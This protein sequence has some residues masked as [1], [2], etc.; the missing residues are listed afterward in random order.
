[1]LQHKFRCTG[2]RSA[3]YAL[4][5]AHTPGH[6]LSAGGDGWV[7]EWN[8]ADPETG[9]VVVNVETQ[10]FSLAVSPPEWPEKCILAGTMAGGL[11][12]VDQNQP[13]LGRNILHHQKGLFDILW[14][15][16]EV[17]TAGGDGAVSRWDATERKVT[18]SFQIS[19]RSVRSLAYSQQHDILAAGASDGNIYWM[20]RSDFT[21]LRTTEAHDIAVFTTCWS[22]DGQYLLSG[23]RDAHLNIW[24]AD[25]IKVSSQPAHWFTINHIAFSPDGAFF[26][27]ASRDKTIKIW[28]AKT[29]ELIKVLETIRDLGHINS[30]NRLLWKEEYLISCSDDRAIILWGV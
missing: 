26:A 28:D 30:V 15:E 10:L 8:L 4:A 13:E 7:T 12:W 11:H 16:N 19:N 1:M 2:H 17:F 6:F 22:P 25:G 20:K 27:T 14:L 23:G 18:E 9:K 29:F 5:P 24:D 3:L 21:L